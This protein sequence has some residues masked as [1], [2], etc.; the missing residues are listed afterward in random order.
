MRYRRHQPLIFRPQTPASQQAHRA[1]HDSELGMFEKTHA[2]SARV[3]LYPIA[4]LKTAE[5]R[6]REIHEDMVHSA[7]LSRDA[8]TLTGAGA[9]Q[10]HGDITDAG[11]RGE[12]RAGIAS[13]D[14][15][16]VVADCRAR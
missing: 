2:L 4:D 8:T 9:V 16:L 6:R 15:A 13:I 1:M 11:Q 14:A 5:N 3:D 10:H 12:A 7:M